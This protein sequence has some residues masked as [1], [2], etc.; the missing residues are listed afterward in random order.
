MAVC[1]SC[2]RAAARKQELEGEWRGVVHGGRRW[3]AGAWPCLSPMRA[4]ERCAA[5]AQELE[6]RLARAGNDPAAIAELNVQLKR[7]IICNVCSENWRD[8]VVT[9][10]GHMFCHACLK[11]RL[12]QRSRKCPTCN[13]A[14]ELKDVLRVTVDA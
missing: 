2:D 4:S 6:A 14:F 7:Q 8:A 11:Q 3:E 1:L 12:A 10:C 13:C 5:R 9:R